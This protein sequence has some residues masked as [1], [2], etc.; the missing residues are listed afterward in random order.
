MT[1]EL[2]QYERT[3]K[4]KISFGLTPKFEEEFRTQ[5]NKTVFFPIAKEIIEKIGWHLVFEDDST[6]EA[7][8]HAEGFH[9]GQKI[10][11]KYQSGKVIVNSKSNQSPLF[12]FGRNSKR[13]KLFIYAFQKTNETQILETSNGWNSCC[14]HFRVSNSIHDSKSYLRHWDL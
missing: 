5:L 10:T 11:I 2:K 7:K 4:K 12:D 9:W 6:L 3:I 8:Q 13:V 1:E 14:Y